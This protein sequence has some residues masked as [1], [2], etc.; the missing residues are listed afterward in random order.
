[1]TG[2]SGI[3]R[4]LRFSQYLPQFG[5]E[6]IVLTAKP[7]AYEQTST[8]QMLYIPDGVHVERVFALDAARH[9]SV[10]GV[11]PRMLADPDRWMSWW[12]SGVPSGLRLIKRFRPKVLWSTFPIPTAH[13]IGLTLQRFTGLPWIADFRDVMTEDDYPSDPRLARSWRRLERAIIGASSQAVFTTQGAANMY[14]ERYDELPEQHFGV[15][16]NGYD[17]Q[18]FS[19][20]DYD[21][22]AEERGSCPSR[23][24]RLLH[25]GV[26]Y[27][28]ERNPEPFFRALG[29][30][31]S[32]G[33][34]SP[35]KLQIVLRATGHDSYIARLL[36]RYGISDM[37]VLVPA[38]SY[39][40][41]LREMIAVD[42][43]ILLQGSN[44]SRQV[45]AK[46]YEYLR[47]G[48]PILGL[49]NGDTENTLRAAGI[50]TTAPLESS[51]KIA[52]A[53][54]TFVQLL[55][56]GEAPRASDDSVR[57]HSRVTKAY[58][59]SQVLGNAVTC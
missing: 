23:P 33:E 50:D 35:A 17:E 8:D 7:C 18:S 13:R 43:L 9:L 48:R 41:A 40:S 16:E 24:I 11:Y 34:I 56:S 58:E 53:L 19:D 47:S 21:S 59:L 57:K 2:T 52:K 26:I 55:S 51:P 42:G 14:A 32:T 28:S 29:Q 3:Q 20:I 6:P 39:R 4:T 38:I 45:P 30:L 1:M 5:W 25:S 44:C 12:L 46:L 31:R 37:V 10:R 49:A 27:P 22:V 15:I 54:R 36:E